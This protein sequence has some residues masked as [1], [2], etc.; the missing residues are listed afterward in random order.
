[1]SLPFCCVVLCCIVLCCVMLHIL[2]RVVHHT[3]QPEQC[4]LGNKYG[5]RPFPY[6]IKATEFEV[7]LEIA[8]SQVG[9]KEEIELILEWFLKVSTETK[10]YSLVETRLNLHISLAANFPQLALTPGSRRVEASFY[11]TV[12]LREGEAVSRED[13]EYGLHS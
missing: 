1:M 2:C 13:K 9:T 7:L 10:G 4:L 5:Y 6:R 8:K 11:P 12:G 3:T